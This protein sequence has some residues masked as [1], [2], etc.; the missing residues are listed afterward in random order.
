MREAIVKCFFKIIFDC[1]GLFYCR[2]LVPAGYALSRQLTNIL[3]SEKPLKNKFLIAGKGHIRQLNI[4][5]LPGKG[6]SGRY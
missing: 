5:Q 6:T 1:A 2:I 3:V 4:R